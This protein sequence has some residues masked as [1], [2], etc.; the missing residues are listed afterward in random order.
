MTWDD[1]FSDDEI[2]DILGALGARGGRRPFRNVPA[3]IQEGA[4]VGGFCLSGQA[5]TTQHISVQPQMWFRAESMHATD[6]IPD[7]V[8]VDGDYCNFYLERFARGAHGRIVIVPE[9]CAEILLLS[10]KE[11]DVVDRGADKSVLD[12]LGIGDPEKVYRA[13]FYPPP[14]ASTRI[15]EIFIG[16]SKEPVGPVPTSAFSQGFVEF[17]KPL[18]TCEA[19]IP[20]TMSVYFHR[21]AYFE[22]ALKG[23]RLR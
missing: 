8:R 6:W 2:G 1:M 9:D 14:G 17:P 11:F 13:K 23:K 12:L 18:R 21:D 3:T 4:I 5:G 7:M 19:P 22:A 15:M 10:P 16:A 20:I